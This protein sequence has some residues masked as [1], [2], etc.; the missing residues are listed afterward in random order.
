MPM[1]FNF[2]SQICADAN[3]LASAFACVRRNTVRVRS[4]PTTDVRAWSISSLT[5]SYVSNMLL[6]SKKIQCKINE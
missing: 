6:W 4:C 1:P 2:Y 5:S 3:I